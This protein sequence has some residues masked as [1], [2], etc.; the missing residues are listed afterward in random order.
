MLLPRRVIP[1]ISEM[2]AFE[3]V[4]RH[5]NFSAAA[6]ELY[7]TQG[8]ISKQIRSLELTLGVSLFDRRRKRLVLTRQ[9]RLLLPSIASIIEQISSTTYKI[10]SSSDKTNNIN[11]SVFSTFSSRWLIPRFAR[12][13]AQYP[14]FN[15]NVS[16]VFEAFT[17]D[18]TDCDVAI[19]YGQAVWPNG[20]LYHLFDEIII[21]VCSP[22]YREK[23]GFSKPEDFNRINLIQLT[24]RPGLWEYWLSH[25][26]IKTSKPLHGNIFDQFNA[27]IEAALSG[28]GAA[29]VPH[30]F[31]ERELHE[32]KLV[33]LSDELLKGQGAYYAVIP[34]EKQNNA[35]IMQFI[36]WIRKESAEYR[37]NTAFHE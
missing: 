7:L 2:I 30:I 22:A 13:F 26:G 35:S 28:L 11:L 25:A 29:L 12:L 31:V 10:I 14:D 36:E 8:A 6:E 34:T 5:E 27:T 37:I 18:D 21:P 16:T 1:S 19:H 17:F 24:T 3:A 15:V 20:I 4:A 32:G 23:T 33:V 9:A